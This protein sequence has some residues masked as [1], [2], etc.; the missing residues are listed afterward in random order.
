MASKVRNKDDKGPESH[1]DVEAQAS[2][3]CTIKV[4]MIGGVIALAEDAREDEF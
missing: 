3:R 1:N 2:S 4:Q